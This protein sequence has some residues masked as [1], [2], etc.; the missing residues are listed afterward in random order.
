MHTG[1]S[2]F[3]DTYGVHGSPINCIGGGNYDTIE[4][5]CFS[6]PSQR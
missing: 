2:T 3:S 6:L 1:F 5:T 4:N